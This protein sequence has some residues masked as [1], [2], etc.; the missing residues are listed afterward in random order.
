MVACGEQF[1]RTDL[2]LE[3]LLVI[4]EECAKKYKVDPGGIKGEQARFTCQKCGH[5]IVV[6]KSDM[7]AA[8][9]AHQHGRSS[10]PG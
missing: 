4:C 2:R 9:Y 8:L 10:V 3:M 7:K 5:S 1:V 6:R